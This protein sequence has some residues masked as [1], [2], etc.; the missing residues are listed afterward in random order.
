[1][2]IDVTNTNAAKKVQIAFGSN[3]QSLVVD[4]TVEEANA[5]HKQDKAE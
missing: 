5:L 4:K 3:D 2:V 1:M